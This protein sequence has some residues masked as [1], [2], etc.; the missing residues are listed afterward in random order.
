MVF[1]WGT[2]EIW[3]DQLLDENAAIFAVL[4]SVSRGLLNSTNYIDVVSRF[5]DVERRKAERARDEITT[6]RLA[7]VEQELRELQ[8]TERFQQVLDIL[9][10]ERVTEIDHEKT[11]LLAHTFGPVYSHALALVTN[12]SIKAEILSNKAKFL[13]EELQEATKNY[14]LQSRGNV[15]IFIRV[16][17]EPAIVKTAPQVKEPNIYLE[18]KKMLAK[19]KLSL[20]LETFSVGLS[21]SSDLPEISEPPKESEAQVLSD[22]G[23]EVTV[24]VYNW[25]CSCDQFLDKLNCFHNVTGAE[26]AAR[27]HSEESSIMSRWF[28]SSSCNHI[29]PLPICMHLLAVVIA[30]HN[31]ESVEIQC[32]QIS[33]V[34]QI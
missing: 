1:W 10:A 7:K 21:K 27:L 33:S 5:L 8:G 22:L 12:G 2:S 19:L 13:P 28:A 29:S 34:M 24:N 31:I 16:S 15:P 32:R 25:F 18:I 23:P 14:F 26:M 20:D 9:N 11:V 6:S 4:P 30:V 17:K 3:M